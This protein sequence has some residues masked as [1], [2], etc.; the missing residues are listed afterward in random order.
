MFGIEPQPHSNTIEDDR[1]FSLGT[2]QQDRTAGQT[3]LPVR[4][5]SVRRLEMSERRYAVASRCDLKWRHH[6]ASAG[7]P[8][9]SRFDVIDRHRIIRRGPVDDTAL[10]YRQN[11]A[12]IGRQPVAFY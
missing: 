8:I 10:P 12:K 4:R 3:E 5:A 7:V 2:G 1:I 6:H 11:A 9:E